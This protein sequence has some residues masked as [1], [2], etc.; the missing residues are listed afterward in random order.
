MTQTIIKELITC[1]ALMELDKIQVVLK[2]Y[3][4]QKVEMKRNKE[5]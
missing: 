2:E 4:Q 1:Q 5:K 3:H